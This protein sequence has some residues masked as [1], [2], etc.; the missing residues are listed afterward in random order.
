MKRFSNYRSLLLPFLIGFVIL[1]AVDF[2]STQ[3]LEQE[4]KYHRSLIAQ[5][6]AGELQSSLQAHISALTGLNVVYQNFVDINHYDFQQYG[7]SITANNAGFRRLFYIAPNK[8]IERVYPMDP[9]DTGLVGYTLDQ[10]TPLLQQTVRSHQS[11]LSGFITFLDHRHTLIAVT[12]IY[13]N[14]R[15][16]LGYGIG[17]IS[18]QNIWEPL[19]HMAFL[20]KY[21]VQL[22][23]SD[24]HPFF[25]SV[26]FR[27]HDASLTKLIFPIT[28]KSWTLLLQ[29]IYSTS[30]T[31]IMQRVTIWAFG[32][33]V[34]S[35]ILLM[36]TRSKRYH[37]N[38]DKAQQQFEQIFQASPDGIVMLGDKLQ[39]QLTNPPIQSWSGFSE[40][41][42]ASKSFFDLFTCQC[43]YLEK[44]KELSFLLCTSDQFSQDLPEVLETQVTEAK[45]DVTR[46]LR[47]NASKIGSGNLSDD[48]NR[49]ICLLGDI[50][51]S[52]ELNRVKETFV[53]TLTHDLKTP[54]IAQGM[55]LE[56]L[57]S[58]KL[59]KISEQQN[60]LLYGASASVK[61]LLD[62]VNATLLFYQLESAHLVL[63]KQLCKLDELMKEV[64]ETL[65]PIME[66]RQL[67]FEMQKAVNM[68]DVDVDPIQ[69]KR[70]FHNLLSNA[71]SYAPKNSVIKIHFEQNADDQVLIGITNEG[72]GIE[73]SEL[74]KIF[75]KYYTLSRKFKQ[76]GTGLG[77]YISRRI[78]ELHGGRIWAES[79]V[80]KETSFFVC[81]PCLQNV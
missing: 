14:N 29:P 26:H 32:L 34:L 78:V 65:R 70:V 23:D 2:F 56:T 80:D 60:K 73:P 39:F 7:K 10:I 52:K 40:N 81:L 15:E 16:F 58:G 72:K 59:G 62:I 28:G 75:E 71:M 13:R 51:A 3:K 45:T 61:D 33:L 55:V 50:S 77:L 67:K 6:L 54:L 63:Q 66:N 20:Q 19:N 21:S 74:P 4:Q 49:F 1:I 12:P 48:S 35:L 68:P 37:D 31:L 79:E 38:L 27:N 30:A 41:E 47:L 8:K 64:I 53:A 22:L 9:E 24:G 11:I 5:Q 17:E 57:L 43:P 46:T 44:C 18:M 25:S 76:I 36:M 69:L 42:L